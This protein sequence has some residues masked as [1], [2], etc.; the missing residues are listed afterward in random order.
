MASK[1]GTRV[2]RVFSWIW[3]VIDGS[4][5][6]AVNLLFLFI[7]IGCFA[8]MAKKPKIPS[9]AALVIAPHGQIVEQL[10]RPSGSTIVQDALSDSP[11][12][13]LLRDLTDALK[14]AKDDHKISSV[15]LDLGGLDASGLTVLEDLR[16][17]LADFKKSGKKVICYG[18][19]FSQPQYYVATA[20]DEIWLNP[21]GGVEFTGLGRY[22]S[23]YKEA[24]DRL[25]VDV[26]V[27]RVGEYKSAVEP[28]IRN[29]MSPESKEADL[30]WMSDLWGAWV[31]DVAAARH[32]KDT[33]IN[34]YIV[35][36]P[37]RAEAAKGDLAKLA[38]DAKLVDKLGYK[39]EANARMI[40]PRR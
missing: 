1:L 37:E 5:R 8:L 2:R 13:T 26:H 19:N 36:A 30:K 16:A 20:A 17:A 27:F 24:L 31:R 32:L 40:E 34:D 33:D 28:Y 7:V 11:K 9:E 39:D 29:D 4:R 25:D 14:E 10:G 35:K 22:H 15:Y 38:M 23:Y 3:K 6:V 18:D 12:E 21:V